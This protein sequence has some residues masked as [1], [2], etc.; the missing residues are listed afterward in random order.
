[1][2]AEALMLAELMDRVPLK[3][4]VSASLHG[5]A[6]AYSS[7]LS[8]NILASS[9]HSVDSTP[10]TQT[11]GACSPSSRPGRSIWRACTTSTA[12]ADSSE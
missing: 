3:D 2:Q 12:A 5:I 10:P 4:F 8:D 11:D 1:M 7:A 9:L 6:S